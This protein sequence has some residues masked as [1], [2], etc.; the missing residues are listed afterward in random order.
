MEFDGDSQGPS[1]QLIF[2]EK[3]ATTMDTPM[4]DLSHD[5]LM[6]LQEL[7][8][9]LALFD[10]TDLNID[11]S[12]PGATAT[13]SAISV[14]THEE[15]FNKNEQ[16]LHTIIVD[17]S[18]SSLQQKIIPIAESRGPSSNK[19]S[20]FRAY[21]QYVFSMLTYMIYCDRDK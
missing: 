7:D 11:S 19:Q 17:T 9:Q 12:T 21:A 3:M 14:S 13:G 18:H 20:S 4:H 1:N 8:S 5:T 15:F 16:P 2:T 10:A 6:G